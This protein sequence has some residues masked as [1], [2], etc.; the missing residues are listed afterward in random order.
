MSEP[1]NQFLGLEVGARA[2]WEQ[3]ARRYAGKGRGLGAVCSYGMPS[4]YNGYIHLTQ[5][6]ALA[7]WLR[8]SPD[9]AV[10]EVGCGLGRWS[11]RL[12][13]SGA[14]VTGIDVSSTMVEKARQLTECAGLAS[15]CRFLVADLAELALGKR[16][17]RILGV[18]VL[19]H[20]LDSERFQAAVKR[21]A[22]H[23]APGGR[24]VL[25]EAA[26]SRPVKRCDSEIFCARETGAYCDAFERAGLRC[27]SMCGVDPAPFKTLFLPWYSRMPRPIG[28]VGLATVTALSLPLD[29]LVGRWMTRFS[30]HKV[31]VLANQE[32]A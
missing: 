3:R 10:L 24:L 8:V 6:L 11:Q 13:R 7:P 32:E 26:P 25:L 14:L 1:F 20:I 5:C 16:F 22:A 30:W 28:T 21:L 19:Q 27:V 18:T 4:F 12:A 2:Y 31:F 15:R 9:T 17:E 29:V 23:L